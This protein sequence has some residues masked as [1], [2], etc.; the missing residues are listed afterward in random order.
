ME[1]R[2]NSE[3]TTYSLNIKQNKNLLDKVIIK[4]IEKKNSISTE[5]MPISLQQE[6]TLQLI[7]SLSSLFIEC[8]TPLLIQCA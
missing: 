5:L 3:K 8:K 7:N 4:A 6:F 2:G 1:W